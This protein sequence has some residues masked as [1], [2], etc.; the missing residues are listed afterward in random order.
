MVLIL[1]Q[2][3]IDD[4]S[5]KENFNQPHFDSNSEEEI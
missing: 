4:A 3:S 5:I 2:K 1:L